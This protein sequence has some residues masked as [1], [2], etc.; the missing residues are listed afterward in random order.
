VL[1]NAYL[2]A[3]LARA[4]QCPGVLF[5]IEQYDAPLFDYRKQRDAKTKGWERYATQ[6]RQR[7]REVMDAFQ[8]GYPG[9]T[10][11]LTFGY[12]LPWLESYAGKGS[13]ADCH[14]GL[15]APFVDGLIEATRGGT[16]LVDGHE[17]SYGYKDTARFAAAYRTMEL[18]LLPIVRD[19][20]RYRR[21]FSFGFGLWLDH[22]WRRHGW[23]VDDTAKN[24]FTPEAF[25]AS[26]REALR[27]AD[28]YVWVYSET[29]R[30]WSAEGKSVKLPGAY[31]AALRRA[32]GNNP[33]KQ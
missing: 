3:W 21:V 12:C 30:W 11:F 4:G 25:E 33:A 31:D 18:D 14:Y 17:S 22:D 1:T 7:G 5:D 27:V 8:R 23:N 20:E 9:L 28:E 6:V 16:R 2:A 10:V 15:L 19:P 13:L 32:R 24:Y 26:V 29:P